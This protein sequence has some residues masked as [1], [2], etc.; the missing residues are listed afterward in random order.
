M[1]V[2]AALIGC[3]LFAGTAYASHLFTEKNGNTFVWEDYD[4]EDGQYCTWLAAG[5]FC[6][7]K[8]TIASVK[9]V[10]KREVETKKVAD[11]KTKSYVPVYNGRQSG[12]SS[13]ASASSSS[14]SAAPT[15][16]S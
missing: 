7:P 1:K 6:V 16:R 3:I 14:R 10:N 8:E 9:K 4:I 15:R 2:I 13:S 11:T 12:G 5:K